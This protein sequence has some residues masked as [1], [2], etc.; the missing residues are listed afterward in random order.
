M[1]LMWVIIVYYLDDI[2]H[3][4]LLYFCTTLLLDSMEAVNFFLKKSPQ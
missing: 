2:M 1:I 3:S 4:Y